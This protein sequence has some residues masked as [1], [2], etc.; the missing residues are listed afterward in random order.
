MQVK[1]SKACYSSRRDAKLRLT[2]NFVKIVCQ[3][4]RLFSMIRYRIRMNEKMRRRDII[5]GIIG[6]HKDFKKDSKE[7]RERIAS[8][9]FE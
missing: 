1:S 2:R 8:Y 4:T 3:R 6:Y 7:S 9:G 5:D